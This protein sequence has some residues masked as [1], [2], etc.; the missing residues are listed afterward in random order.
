MESIQPTE[1][2]TATTTPVERIEEEVPTVVVD[3]SNQARAEGED[4][5]DQ[6]ETEEIV[7][8]NETSE[9]TEAPPIPTE[10]MEGEV[11]GAVGGVPQAQT[12]PEEKSGILRHN[13]EHLSD[14]VG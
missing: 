7:V 14:N 4:K 8:S 5:N 12:G 3:D 2:S 10:E 11:D 13:Y 1:P 9:V 6:S